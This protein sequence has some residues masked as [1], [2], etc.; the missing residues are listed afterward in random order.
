MSETPVDP[1]EDEDKNYEAIRVIAEDLNVSTNSQTKFDFNGVVFDVRRYTSGE[2]Q[3]T[4]EIVLRAAGTTQ[5]LFVDD[6]EIHNMFNVPQNTMVNVNAE[7]KGLRGVTKDPVIFT[8]SNYSGS[9]IREIAASI[10]VNIVKDGIP[11]QLTANT[12]QVA[13]KIA[14]GDDY[15]WCDEQ[16]DIDAK[17]SKTDG[18]SLFKEYVQGRLNNDWYKSK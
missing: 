7:A 2:K 15:Q 9:T 3:G 10:K 16:Q 5:N 12:G 6:K 14:V 11:Y 1:G 13:S 18:T 17:Y 4:V 8:P